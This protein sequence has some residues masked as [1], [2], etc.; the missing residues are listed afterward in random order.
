M[1][2][3]GMSKFPR[4]SVLDWLSRYGR[5]PSPVPDQPIGQFFTPAAMGAMLI[6][7][8]QRPLQEVGSCETEDGNTVR[9]CTVEDS[10]TPVVVGKNGRYVLRWP[11]IVQLAINA[12]LEPLEDADG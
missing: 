4:W 6:A 12:G 9:L 11:E 2:A 8:T 1:G 7:A 10:E 5:I 3:A